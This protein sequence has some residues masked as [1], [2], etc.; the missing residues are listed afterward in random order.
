MIDLSSMLKKPLNWKTFK[1]VFTSM[2]HNVHLFA[3]LNWD[4]IGERGFMTNRLPVE[5]VV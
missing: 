3:N 4:E 1:D 5:E 2:T